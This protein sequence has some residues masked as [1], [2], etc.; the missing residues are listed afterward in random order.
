MAIESNKLKETDMKNRM[1]YYVHSTDF[2]FDNILI[3][4]KSN[5]NILF[6]DISY[7]TLFIRFVY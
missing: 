2:D 3:D 1:Y 5:E 7:K 4:E 6:Y